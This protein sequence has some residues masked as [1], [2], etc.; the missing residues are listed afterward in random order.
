MVS[1]I[2]NETIFMK[3][4]TINQKENANLK[5]ITRITYSYRNRNGYTLKKNCEN[6]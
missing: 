4:Q 3:N 2:V 1:T 5:I 6:I